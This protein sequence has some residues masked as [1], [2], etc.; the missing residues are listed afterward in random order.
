M[1]SITSAAQQASTAPGI[2]EPH[3]TPVERQERAGQAAGVEQ[4]KPASVPQS[5]P[6]APSRDQYVKGEK[7]ASAGVYQ[8]SRDENGNPRI[9]FDDP[10]KTAPAADQPPVA[11]DQGED[12]SS[13]SPEKADGEDKKSES[14]TANTDRVD[15]EIKRLKEKQEKL[16]QQLA[17]AGQDPTKQ[18]KLRQQLDQVERE[19]QMKD[20]DSYRRQNTTFSCG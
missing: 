12:P 20:N 5:G 7:P 14:C 18:E 6:A 3:Q 16:E 15:A 17:K 9:N 13:D 19:L 2:W 4:A 8:M 11:A 1:S 10:E